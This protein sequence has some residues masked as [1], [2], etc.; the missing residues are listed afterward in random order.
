MT[1]TQWLRNQNAEEMGDF[2]G[3][4]FTERKARL[5]MLACCRRHPE[6][7]GHE[8][9]AK[10]VELLTAHYADPGKAEKPFDGVAIRQA[11][12][13]LEAFA[14]STTGGPVRGLAFGVVAAAEPVSVMNRLAESFAYLVFSCIHDVAFGVSGE[15]TGGPESVAQADLFREVLGNPCRPVAVDQAWLT[16]TVVLLARHIHLL[17]NF[18]PMPILADALQEAGCEDTAIL[19]HCRDTAQ[20]H[21]R[22]CWVLDQLLGKA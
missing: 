8:A 5:L 6:H 2:Y 17:E 9:V 14:S 11:F 19:G 21:V 16:D 4:W 22:G 12:R 10:M 1:E 13:K 18:S 3:D 7:L 15:H 20:T